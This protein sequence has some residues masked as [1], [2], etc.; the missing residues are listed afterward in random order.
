MIDYEESAVATMRGYLLLEMMRDVCLVQ[1]T[2]ILSYIHVALAVSDEGHRSTH[3]DE[4]GYGGYVD[5]DPHYNHLFYV[6][7]G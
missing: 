7:S 5:M 6:I 2:R 3:P 4:D 1:V